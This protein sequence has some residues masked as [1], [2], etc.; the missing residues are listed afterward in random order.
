MYRVNKYVPNCVG[1]DRLRVENVFSAEDVLY[2][3]A[4]Q[5]AVGDSKLYWRT[6][7]PFNFRTYLNELTCDMLFFTQ[8]DHGQYWGSLHVKTDSLVE[9]HQFLQEDVFGYSFHY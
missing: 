3:D 1:N 2:T 7:S 5:E 9:M 6:S 8:D 4:Y